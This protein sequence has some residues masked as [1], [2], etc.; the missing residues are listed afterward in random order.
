MVT[1]ARVAAG[2]LVVACAVSVRAQ[3]AGT[4]TG[5]VIDETG[6]VLPGV[7]LALKN[8]ATG[9]M[10]TATTTEDGRYVFAGLPPGRY[11]IRASL[12]GFHIELRRLDVSVD[13]S[14]ALSITLEIF[15]PDRI[16]TVAA[17]LVN[18]QTS[19]LSFLVGEKA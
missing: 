10:R 11:E 18:T 13:E 8:T 4:V 15:I 16:E 19:E 9:L 2:L 5:T 1:F 6:G 3:T 7:S 17:P 14:V 12:E